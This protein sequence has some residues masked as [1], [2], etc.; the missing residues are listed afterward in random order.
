MQDI[1]KRDRSLEVP[2]TDKL[3]SD[4]VMFSHSRAIVMQSSHMKAIRI[5]QTA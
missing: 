5:L 1:L 4:N 3:S 2:S